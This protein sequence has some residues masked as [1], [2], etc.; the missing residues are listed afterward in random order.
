MTTTHDTIYMQLGQK[1]N[2]KLGDIVKVVKMLEKNGLLEEFV[3]KANERG[4]FATFEAESTNFVKGFVDIH[5]LRRDPIGAHILIA[6]GR[7]AVSAEAAATRAEP[8]FDCN[9]A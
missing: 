8:I 2:M 1:I 3:V 4:V 7:K 6:P 5:G 9:L